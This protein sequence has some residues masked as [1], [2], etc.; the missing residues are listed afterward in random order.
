[1]RC[2]LA[3]FTI[4]FTT[5]HAP[6]EPAGADGMQLFQRDNLVAWCIVPFDS[7]KR[8]PTQRVEMLKKLGFKKYA[9]DWRTEHLPSFDE[10]VGL[11]KKAGIELTAV[12]FPANL[13]A[14][15][16]KLLEV[17]KK[18]EV[19][20]QLW[21]T[22]GE[23][24]G[25]TQAEKVEA[26][27]KIIRPI[28]EAADKL[29]C[30]VALYNH[31]GWFGEPENQ[32]AI[33]ESLKLKNL[34]I[35]Y[36]QHHGHDH[37]ERFPELLKKMMPHL[38][39]LNLN[40]MAKDGE[41]LGKKILPL[42]QGELD[43]KLLKIIA[44][45][46]YKGPIG[47][48]GHTNDDAEERLRDNLDG[49][50]WLLPQLAGKP[51][52]AKPKYRTMSAQPT[53]TTGWLAE[54]KPEYR[55]PPITVECRAKVNSKN[56][57]NIL[58][59]SDTKASAAH[60]E[61]FTWPNTGHLTVYMPGM[62]PDHVRS[63]ADVC[64][65][66]WHQVAMQY[67][68]DRVRLFVDGKKVAEQ[69]LKRE[70]TATVDGGLAFA[71]LVEGGLGC[72][73][74]LD[75]VRISKGTIE[76]TEKELKVDDATL[77]LWIF[78]SRDKP[79]EDSSKLKNAAK[80]VAVATPAPL[81][82][83]PGA[84]LT[85]TDPK[86]KV[87]LLDRSEDDAYMAVKLDAAGNLFVGGRERVFVFES[88]GKGG[89]GPRRELLRFPQDSIIIGLE[90]RGEDLYV[91]ASHALYLVPG[92]R[93]QREG[94]TPKR[95][96]WGVPLDYH[97]SFHC[98]AWG[99]DGELYLDHGDPLLNYGDWSRPDHW[100][101][102]TLYAGPDGTKV[103]YTG[104]GA[105]LKVHPDGSN[106]RVVAR[107]LRGPV[108]LAFD[109]H[110][111]L[112]TNDNDHES[113]PDQY[114][115]AR[116]LHVSPHADFGWPRGWMA[117]K[118]PDRADLLDC[119]HPALG[120]GVPCDLTYYD[121]PALPRLRDSL[122][123]CR[124]D[125]FAVTQ[126]PLKPKGASFTAEELVFA[127]GANQCRPTGITLD[128]AGRVFVTCHYLAGNVVTPHCP[129]D[130]VMIAPADS[131]ASRF[132]ETK[133]NV[134]E[135]WA[136]LEEKSWNVRRRAHLALIRRGG[137]ALATAIER[138]QKA[139][140]DDPAAAHLPWL[141]AA[142]GNEKA[143]S[144]LDEFTLDTKKPVLRLQA[145]RALA[146]ASI[147]QR[148][149][150]AFGR[151][152]KDAN[153]VIQLA[154]LE[155]L[156]TLK[157]VPIDNVA[158]L[159]GSYDPALR[160]TAAT[161]LARGETESLIALSRS[162]DARIRLAA[163]LAAGTAITV[164]PPDALPPQGVKLF[165]PAKSAF[166]SP[167]LRFADARE[168]VDITKLGPVGSYTT[169]QRWAAVKHTQDE[170]Q[171]FK[172]LVAALDDRNDLVASQAAYY[173]GWLRDPRSEAA[174]ARVRFEL[175]T[176][177]LKDRPRIALKEAWVIGRLTDAKTGQAIEAG[178]IDLAV[179]VV[180]G[181]EKLNWQSISASGKGLS[182]PAGNGNAYCYFRIQSRE[183]QLALLDSDKELRVWH[184][185]R[186]IS[187][188]TD[189]TVVLDLQPGSNDILLRTTESGHLNITVRARETVSPS[190][191]EK[192]DGASLTERLKNAK[193]TPIPPEFLQI[194][195]STEG[196]K[197]DAARGRKLFG[198]LGCA[199]CHA[200]I[201]DQAGGGAP[202]L[203]EAGKRFTPAHIAESI[204]L[205]DRLVAEEFRATRVTTTDEQSLLGLVVR[206]SPIELEL[207][208][209]DTTRRV[210]KLTD[211]ATRK[212]IAASP[213]PAGLVKTPDELRD[214]LTYLLSDNP[215]PP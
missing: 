65:S 212:Q 190:L 96:L 123:M 82:I 44:E 194:N 166:F 30:S 66:K 189:G 186:P 205:P 213:M 165:F 102:W 5:Q 71:R 98:L 62:K 53:A 115:P 52:G 23:P 191:P 35:V 108:G 54:G 146:N 29:G 206:E 33:I 59:A 193:N 46:G 77:G 152:L 9:Y 41:K 167:E 132:D 1:M 168:P 72:D 116:L 51:A 104:A 86:L 57:F 157:I 99:P 144:V 2:L 12:W 154:G 118:S 120:R 13:D 129:S 149:V 128:A 155:G 56:S 111:N 178:P 158:A 200:I 204:L 180:N 36:N 68:S 87:T 11:L 89:F 81:T 143:F 17:I 137:P 14:D 177:G 148:H 211:I 34:G 93:V 73:G 76:P 174:V 83:P 172:L 175:R 171:F 147:A 25:K 75:R 156:I 197:G 22:M 79:A 21:V 145:I 150:L 183:R 135:L 136:A 124:W 203:A 92:G 164:P 130:L 40:G 215:L 159:A 28:A 110:W 90:F 170:E 55:T 49:L 109:H 10:E 58:V 173:L 202:S 4:I 69:E 70:K 8:T 210:V 184:N 39:A 105:V 106:P 112:F 74:E 6:T 26:A 43:L 176:R 119:V 199:K 80:P 60:W 195:W 64:D 131:A 192:T 94:L 188:E 134:D 19:K 201:S 127:Q 169:A 78:T 88:D 153:P 141:V 85:V 27:A 31:G 121:E 139:R 15:A 24:A 97:V 162:H 50:D 48:L 122:L 16:K 91:L 18:H 100:G 47:I 125:R 142:I 187:P 208:L 214:L 185:G 107:G 161:L 209:P 179:P 138:M 32:L 140:D 38:F 151:A 133:A 45:S 114:T 103:P 196:K 42:G 61:I 207:L 113:R 181:T 163:V 95:I 160:Q 3:V 126:Y 198:T 84:Q 63:E 20:T 117:S 182:L 101:Y 7:K 37:I 67:E